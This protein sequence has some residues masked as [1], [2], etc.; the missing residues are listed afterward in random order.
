M[1]T[2]AVKV[3]KVEQ[4][5]PHDNADSLEII[6]IPGSSW[7]CVSQKDTFK[8]GDLAIYIE[9]DY[10]V[11]TNRPEFSFLSK[12]DNGDKHR[13]RAVRLRGALSYGLLI[14]VSELTDADFEVEEGDDVMEMLGITRYEPPAQ[15]ADA[16]LLAGPAPSAPKFDVESLA[17]HPDA[18]I[19][20]E[21]VVASEKI[22]GANARYLYQ[23]GVFYMGSRTRWLNPNTPHIW[24]LA[25]AR[26]RGPNGLSP[27][28]SWCRANEG[29]ILYGEVY[30]PVQSLKYGEKTPQFRAFLVY[31]PPGE[32]T[33]PSDWK[34]HGVKAVPL[35]YVGPWDPKI[36]LPYAE[37]DSGMPN[38]P[39]G[40][41]MEG[42]VLMPAVMRRDPKL[43]FV[44]LKHISARY[45]TS[46]NA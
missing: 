42:I 23:D 20:G 21:L 10:I 14:P 18:L 46:K 29:S 11:P 35:V 38:A 17:N 40:H 1:S 28:E 9:P 41:M 27:I 26:D 45:W 37:T 2:H 33:V 12:P 36:V 3:I 43:G 4:V 39:V 13:M 31:Q 15:H 5:L 24:A 44:I 25:A 34:A 32:W 6:P 22:H 8:P 7:Q 30:G 16:D 19:P